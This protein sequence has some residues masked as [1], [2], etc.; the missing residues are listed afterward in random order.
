MSDGK[1]TGFPADTFSFGLNTLFA[2]FRAGALAPFCCVWRV[3]VGL[4]VSGFS[5]ARVTGAVHTSITG[6]ATAVMSRLFGNI[7]ITGNPESQVVSRCFSI[8][9][10]RQPQLGN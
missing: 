5:A 10:I 6:T 8:V 2:G 3:S 9:A 7:D 1:D 4:V